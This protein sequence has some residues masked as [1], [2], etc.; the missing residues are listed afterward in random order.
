MRISINKNEVRGN[1]YAKF[2]VC[3]T[4]KGVFYSYEQTVP[5]DEVIIEQIF[6]KPRKIGV[7]SRKEIGTEQQPEVMWWYRF[8]LMKKTMSKCI[9]L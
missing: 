2:Q 5:L 9:F 4:Y 7:H 6:E 8:F 3:D 1:D